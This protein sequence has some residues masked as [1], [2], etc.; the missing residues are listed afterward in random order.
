MTLLPTNHSQAEKPT[1]S[2]MLT[3]AYHT[4]PRQAKKQALMRPPRK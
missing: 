2:R 1:V 4:N 3:A